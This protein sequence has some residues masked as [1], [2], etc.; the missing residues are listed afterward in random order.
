M[1]AENCIFCFWLSFRNAPSCS[2]GTKAIWE[3]S[4]PS[5]SKSRLRAGMRSA[6]RRDQRRFSRLGSQRFGGQDRLK[7]FAGPGPIMDQ[8]CG[9]AEGIFGCFRI[10]QTAQSQIDAISDRRILTSAQALQ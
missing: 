9:L 8:K 6:L 5:R 4:R 2:I 7:R 3:S 10:K 1:A